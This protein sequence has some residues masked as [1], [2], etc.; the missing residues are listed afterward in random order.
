MYIGIF[1]P[2]RAVQTSL[3]AACLSGR[4]LEQNSRPLRD[5][6]QGC[7]YPDLHKV[8]NIVAQ[9]PNIDTIGS[10]GPII[11]S[12]FGGPGNSTGLESKTIQSGPTGHGTLRILRN[13]QDPTEP[14]RSYGTLRIL[15][16]PKDPTEPSGSYGT[17]R[18]LRN[19]KDPTEP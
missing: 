4:V 19:P 18:I 8:T 1:K 14:S 17:L 13:P 10:I 2:F 15:R 5:Y 16:N 7:S 11:L 3:P 9:Y 6:P 12:T